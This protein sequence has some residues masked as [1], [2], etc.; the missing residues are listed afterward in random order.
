MLVCNCRGINE[1]QVNVAVRAGATHWAEVHSH[2]GTEPSCGKC[3]C[4]IQQVIAE[5]SFQKNEGD[6]APLFG[7]PALAK[8]A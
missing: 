4:E 8:P 6:S 7:T 3:S 1:K 5:H 2:Y